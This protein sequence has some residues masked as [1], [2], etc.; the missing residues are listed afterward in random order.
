MKYETL[1]R[2]KKA[3]ET[4][5]KKV[6]STNKPENNPTS[7]VISLHCDAC[8]ARTGAKVVM[9][10][11]E[12]PPDK[13]LIK[14]LKLKF[15]VKHW[16]PLKIFK[17]TYIYFKCP[18]CHWEKFTKLQEL[19]A[20]GFINTDICKDRPENLCSWVDCKRGG[21]IAQTS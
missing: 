9:M 6:W 5:T 15:G 14:L 13:E 12:L 18:V 2:I 17:R 7:V 19:I 11:Y 4:F 21:Y 8:I 3:K 20:Q 1:K 16:I 10:P